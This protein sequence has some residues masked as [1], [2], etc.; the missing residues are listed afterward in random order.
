VLTTKNTEHTKI[1]FLV[2][3]VF[4]RFRLGAK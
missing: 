1:M 2:L 3:F 4:V